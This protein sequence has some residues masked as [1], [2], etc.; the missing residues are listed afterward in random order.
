MAFTANAIDGRGR[1]KVILRSDQE[2]SIMKL[3]KLAK[4]R[5][6]R[7]TV[8]EQA[9][10]RAIRTRVLAIWEGGEHEGPVGVAGPDPYGRGGG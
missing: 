4:A 8:V 2:H 3:Q 5:R 7:E 6:V 9:L 1:N 10:A